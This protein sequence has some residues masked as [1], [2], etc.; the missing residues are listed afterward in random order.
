M[1]REFNNI[2][3]YADAHGKVKIEVVYEGETFLA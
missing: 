1:T 3:L 2:L